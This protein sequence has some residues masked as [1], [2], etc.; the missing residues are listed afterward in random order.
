ML[1]SIRIPFHWAYPDSYGNYDVR[2]GELFLRKPIGLFGK[3]AEVKAGLGYRPYSL[4]IDGVQDLAASSVGAF[5]DLAVYPF[6]PS[7]LFV[8]LRWELINFNWL[9]DA[10]M[11][12]FEQQR[13]F[14]PSDIYTGTSVFLQVGYRLRL[15]DGFG[16]RL[17]AQPGVQ[18]YSVGTGNFTSGNY[19]QQ[20]SSNVTF[21][22]S[23][24]RFVYN[25]NLGIEI[26]L[27]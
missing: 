15:A 26:K 18:Q 2:G 3:N 20:G 7:G 24:Q 12:D 10:S 4:S 13:G 17:Y 11:T 21:S 8:G 22:E 5:A 19:D 25:A 14:R 1:N 6:S 16:L 27:K 9:S 23:Q